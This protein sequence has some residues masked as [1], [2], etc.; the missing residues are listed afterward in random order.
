[1]ISMEPRN[2]GGYVSYFQ[3]NHVVTMGGDYS[4]QLRGFDPRDK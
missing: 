4:V 1:M 3:D 2:M